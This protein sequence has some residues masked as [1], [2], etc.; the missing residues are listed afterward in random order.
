MRIDLHAHSTASDGTDSP[1]E[2]MAAAA[3]AGLDVVAITDHD[4]TAGWAEAVA[5]VAPGLRLVRGA[6]FSCV[7]EGADGATVSLHLLGYLF[8][9]DAEAIT[10]EQTRLRA[11]RRSRLRTMAERMAA[12]G[13]PV[14]PDELLASL[15]GDAPVG[16]PHLA[17][18]L[19]D[20]GVVASVD[21]A[22]ARFLATGGPYYAGRADTAARTAVRM[23]RAAGG[24]PVLAHAYGRRR[25][26][27]IGPGTVRELAAAGLLGLE[28]DHLDHDAT[29][30]DA[31]HGLATEL[32][33]LVT[34]SSDYHGSNKTIRLGQEQTPVESLERIEELAT[35]DTRVLGH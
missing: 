28:V 1:A 31:L 24:V 17:R 3:A 12:D 5:A 34:G 33:L 25:G 15:P 4:T 26:P 10:T 18:V 16:R 22:F 9:P 21:E 29:D 2:L 14:H 30:R 6:E 19:V 32:G 35:S 11:E 8:N 7:A 23:V 20:A 13:F 27:V